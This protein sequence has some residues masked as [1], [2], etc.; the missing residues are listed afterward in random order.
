[1]CGALFSVTID[2]FCS[3]LSSSGTWDVAWQTNFN[4]SR[5]SLRDDWVSD[6][7]LLPNGTYV[8]GITSSVTFVA[9]MILPSGQM[10]SSFLGSGNLTLNSTSV[11]LFGR[12]SLNNDKMTITSLTKVS[13][14]SVDAEIVQAD[15]SPLP[16]TS[17]RLLLQPFLISLSGRLDFPSSLMHV[18][19]FLNV[20]TSLL[21]IMVIPCRYDTVASNRL[22]FL[23]AVYTAA[24]GPWV[25]FGVAVF[26][27][28]TGSLVTLETQIG[29]FIRDDSVGLSFNRVPG[30]IMQLSDGRLMILSVVQS[31]SSS[32]VVL[33]R[34]YQSTE[35]D[36]TFGFGNT[37]TVTY[38]ASISPLVCKSIISTNGTILIACA[39]VNGSLS[40][41]AYT[42]EGDSDP[43]WGLPLDGK[44]F[45]S[46]TPGYSVSSIEQILVDDSSYLI[47]VSLEGTQQ[48]GAIFKFNALGQLESN[49]GIQGM[50]L[51]PPSG[52][53]LGYMISCALVVPTMP[54]YL[55]VAGWVRNSTS[56]MMMIAR[57]GR[58]DGILDSTWASAGVLFVAD[59]LGSDGYVR[60]IFWDSSL[61]FIV[62]VGAAAQPSS[63]PRLAAF[64]IDPVTSTPLCAFGRNAELWRNNVGFEGVSDV[65]QVGQMYYASLQS[66]RTVPVASFTSSD[67]ALCGATCG[68]GVWALSE[69]CDDGNSI[70]GDGCS[71]TCQ[72]EAGYRC[73]YE[74]RPCEVA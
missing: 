34:R 33:E 25:S 16:A 48:A 64:A 17:D 22:F 49:F 56:R 47:V 8:V 5:D 69:A 28:N 35:L 38:S 19:D 59:R 44:L 40:L 23:T 55:Y 1:V 52:S 11:G 29:Y 67:L 27:L 58:Y 70:S 13:G 62:A 6:V 20:S 10:D 42:L 45:Q 50:L 72:L 65:V 26:D 31:Q 41:G 3:K 18:H 46:S 53:A 36:R 71:S 60:K 54:Q 63:S 14:V 15:L 43:A 51:L 4:L 66:S 21:I 32:Y 74:N 57:F 73:P 2:P 12:F 39:T 7:S 37:A 24:R 61:S 30:S 68:D 9:T